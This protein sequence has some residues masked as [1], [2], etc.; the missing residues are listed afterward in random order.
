M[1]LNIK[2]NQEIDYVAATGELMRAHEKNIISTIKTAVIASLEAVSYNQHH[3]ASEFWEA[4]G[5]N[6]ESILNELRYWINV[7][8]DKAPEQINST[9]AE[10]GTT[11][12]VH[13]DGTVTLSS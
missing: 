2:T 8:V 10:A 12:V 6:G 5:T 11:L 3:T 7:L 9:I 4:Q 1:A 13:Q